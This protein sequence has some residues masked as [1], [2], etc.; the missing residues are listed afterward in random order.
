MSS[1]VLPRLP[2]HTLKLLDLKATL[3][4][5]FTELNY[6]ASF[7]KLWWD[8]LLVTQICHRCF[9]CVLYSS[10]L[11]CGDSIQNS[12]RHNRTQISLPLHP[13]DI[14]EREGSV[15]ILLILW[16]L[17]SCHS[18]SNIKLSSTSIDFNG[19]L[20]CDNSIQNSSRHD[21]TQISLPLHP[22]HMMERKGSASILL[23]LWLF[24]SCCS[25]ESMFASYN[26]TCRL[27][28]PKLPY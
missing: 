24:N 22:Q 23:I 19:L 28:S 16:L 8:R 1:S 26:F 4:P 14:M 11:P 15:P 6:C 25:W 2:A 9:S 5:C 21:R 7:E 13:Q 12:S 27:W 3:T 18:L 17:Y 10:T 20:P